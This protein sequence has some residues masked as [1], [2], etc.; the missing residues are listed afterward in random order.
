MAIRSAFFAVTS[1]RRLRRTNRGSTSWPVSWTL[2]AS[3]AAAAR[4]ARSGKLRAYRPAVPSTE[5]APS[6][7]SVL[8][9]FDC[10]RGE[11]RLRYATEVRP[12][13]KLPAYPFP[14]RAMGTSSELPLWRKMLSLALRVVRVPFAA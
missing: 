9:A 2:P 13:A 12:M 10:R 6:R 11:A 4:T 3:V 8:I 5:E 1:Y 14:V 7:G